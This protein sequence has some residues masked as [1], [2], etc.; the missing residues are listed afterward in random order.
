MILTRTPFRVPLG[1][2]GTD[3]PAF[4]EQYGGFL[5][6]VAIDKYMYIAINRPI[7]DSLVRIKYSRTEMVENVAQVQ[8]QLA[9]AALEYYGIKDSIEITSMADINEGTGMGSS[10]SYLVG[11]LKGLQ[12]LTRRGCS[13]QE[14]AEEACH[15]EIDL[16]HKPVG[17]Q[18]QYL[19]AY[20]GFTA[21]D[22][23]RDGTVKVSNVNIGHEIIEELQNK[24]LLFYTG[25]SR[26]ALSI[27][28][29]QSAKAKEE[30]S[31][32]AKSLLRI[33]E[34]GLEIKKAIE[35]GRLDDFGRLLD[36]HWQVKKT[37]STKMSDPKI[38]RLYSLAKD[39]GA[40]GGKIMGAGGG[41][42]FIFYCPGDKRKVREAMKA[43]GLWEMPFRF[44][45][46]GAKTIVDF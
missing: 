40:L 38:D 4:Y 19:A 17:K 25:I 18:D 14:L 29:E 27:L 42:F 28:G 8:H 34:I 2:G 10:G 31:D 7:V 9:R 11:L 3:L 44:E 26:D 36:E 15:I 46:E 13:I 32:V 24:L 23:D 45:N 33:K 12:T 30:Q 16:L 37:M 21:M 1:G 6:S 43:N 41:G 20:G 35:E 22:I 5:F 39:C